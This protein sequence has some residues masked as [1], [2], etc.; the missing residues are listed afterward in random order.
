MRVF[1]W[2]MLPTRCNV[3]NEYFAEAITRGTVKLCEPNYDG[4]F[5]AKA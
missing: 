1:F 4:L 2:H 3:N 5:L